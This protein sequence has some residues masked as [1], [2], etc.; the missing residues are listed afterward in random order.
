MAP[1]VRP[2][3]SR[4]R[5][6]GP[7]AVCSDPDGRR[8]SHTSRRRQA[9]LV[10]ADVLRVEGLSVRYHTP[11]GAVRAVDGITFDLQAGRASRPRRGVGLRQVDDGAGAD[12]PHQ[13]ARPHRGRLGVAR[14]ARPPDALRGGDAAAPAGRDRAGPAGRDELPQPGDPDPRPD[15]RRAPRP[16]RGGHGAAARRSPARSAAP[17]RPRPGGRRHVPAR[18]ERR[19]EAARLHRHRGEPLPE[20]DHRRRADQRP[21]RGRAAAGDGDAGAGPDR[22]GRRRHPGRATT[23]G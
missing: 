3:S 11:G 12:A 9:G 21:G 22:A 10:T 6:R 19:H 8:P 23:W 15:R 16:R 17:G 18:A 7:A 1:G 14:R 13:A 5:P 20:G 2:Y 4:S